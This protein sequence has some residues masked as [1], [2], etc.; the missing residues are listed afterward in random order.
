MARPIHLI[1]GDL[2]FM[3]NSTKPIMVDLMN[4]ERPASLIFLHPINI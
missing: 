4:V 3:N 2:D 1:F